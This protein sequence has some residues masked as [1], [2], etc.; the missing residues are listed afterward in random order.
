MVNGLIA[1]AEGVP[2][3]AVPTTRAALTKMEKELMHVQKKWRKMVRQ[4]RAEEAEANRGAFDD[5]MCPKGKGQERHLSA[6]P[7]MEAVGGSEKFAEMWYKALS[8]A[9]EPQFLVFYPTS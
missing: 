5:W 6:L 8:S 4:Q 9:N 2:G 7:L 3:D 1:H